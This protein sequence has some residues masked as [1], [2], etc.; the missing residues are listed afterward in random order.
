MVPQIMAPE[1]H[2]GSAG[3]LPKSSSET[4]V[5]HAIIVPEYV[6]R[7]NVPRCAE[8]PVDAPHNDGRSRQ[9]PVERTEDSRGLQ[10]ARSIDYRSGGGT[11]ATSADPG[12]RQSIVVGRTVV[13]VGIGPSRNQPD[14]RRYLG[15]EGIGDG[16]EHGPEVSA[17]EAD[18]RDD[19]DG[20]QG[21]DQ[22]VFDRGYGTAVGFQRQPGRQVIGHDCLLPLV[23]RR[24]TARPSRESI[25]SGAI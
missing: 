4:R 10:G 20:D 13:L 1:R 7:G 22:T 21:R 14:C 15:S 17:R 19:H 8:P 6:A 5:P 24:C 12:P 9:R 2:V 16:G 18:R 23:D 3:D 11:Q 25:A